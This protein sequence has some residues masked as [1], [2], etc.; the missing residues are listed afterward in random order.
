MKLSADQL[1]LLR[2]FVAEVE[3][4]AEANM[5]RTHKLEGM[6]YAA[7]K[8]VLQQWESESVTA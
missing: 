1:E 6:H 4:C 8:E 2:R 5:L 3:R 7:L